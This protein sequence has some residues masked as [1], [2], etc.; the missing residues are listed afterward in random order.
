MPIGTAE[1]AGLGDGD[2][3]DRHLGAAQIVEVGLVLGG[4]VHRREC[5]D[6]LEAVALA[7]TGDQG[8]QAVLRRKRVG[9]VGSA[10]P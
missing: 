1:I 10:G 3:H 6:Q 7:A 4:G 2:G 9:H 5:A 8:V